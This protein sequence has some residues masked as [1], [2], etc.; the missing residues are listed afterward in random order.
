MVTYTDVNGVSYTDEDIER[1]AAEQES[2]EGYTG[3]YCGPPRPGR[4]ISVTEHTVTT[5]AAKEA[6]EHVRDREH[7]VNRDR[8][9]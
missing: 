2:P 3:G 6:N 1:W 8:R 4:P 9:A 5:A 7:H